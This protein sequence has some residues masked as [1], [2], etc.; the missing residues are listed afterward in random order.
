MWTRQLKKSVPQKIGLDE[1]LFEQAGNQKKALS[2]TAPARAEN[3][4]AAVRSG[5][6]EVAERAR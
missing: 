2:P 6:S 4:A 1:V 3:P 5:R